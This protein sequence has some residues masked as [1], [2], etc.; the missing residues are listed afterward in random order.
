[1]RDSVREWMIRVAF[2]ILCATAIWTVFGDELTG[3]FGAR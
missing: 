2:L 1:V 3:M